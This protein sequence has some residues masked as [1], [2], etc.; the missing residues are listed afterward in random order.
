MNHKLTYTSFLL[1]LLMTGNSIAQMGRLG[2]PPLTG[3]PE[4]LVSNSTR[5]LESGPK[6]RIVSEDGRLKA[7]VEFETTRPMPAA[8]IHYGPYFHD[9]KTPVPAYRHSAKE[10]L[11]ASSTRH[12]V[13][14][15]LTSLLE[16]I[17]DPGGAMKKLNGGTVC[18]RLVIPESDGANQYIF[19][20][21]FEFRQDRIV[22]CI[23]EG[24]WIDVFSAQ[25]VVISWET[26]R[27]SEGKVVLDGKTYTSA[28]NKHHEVKISGLTGERHS[29][30]VSATADSV[31]VSSRIYEF[32][33]PGKSGKFRFAAMSDSRAGYGGFTSNFNGTNLAILRSL[34]LDAKSNGAEFIIF[35]GDMI[36]G[37]TTDE[38][39]YL[40]QMDA[41]KCSIEPVGHSVP[42]YEGI[43]NHD[44]V[45]DYWKDPRS[46]YGV[47]MDKVFGNSTE[48]LF[49]E[50][51]VNPDNDFPKPEQPEAPSYRETAYYFDWDNTRFISVNSN[52]W[53][54][55]YA[56]DIGGNIEGFVF[57]NQ[58]EWFRNL[59]DK[60]TADPA[61]RHIFVFTHE[62]PFPCSGHL[63]DAMWYNGG[64][65]N[66]NKNIDGMPLDRTHILKSRD[67]LWTAISQ[68][69]KVRAVIVGDEH[70]YARVRIDS[71]T[72]VYPNGRPNPRFKN[73]I[74]ELISGGAGAPYYGQSDKKI[75]WEKSIVKFSSQEHF[76]I[77]EVNQGDVDLYVHSANGDIIEAVRIVEN[78]KSTEKPIPARSIGDK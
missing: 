55:G 14:F 49:A 18:Y 1:I 2:M 9:Q 65:L 27:P 4:D 23:T 12:S 54:A 53:W 46:N 31:T 36:N 3:K 71:K 38:R 16:P 75:P 76:L 74:W 68:N 62:P 60:T 29:Y 48:T 33:T 37:H 50:C 40:A 45:I 64:D 70:N 21:R 30:S 28:L 32:R 42:I 57:N 34:F 24:P 52:Y 10:N 17:N 26:V 47:R 73:P 15:D 5:I 43:G 56:E 35:A 67:R 44:F 25:E 6:T 78:G 63:H 51:F 66:F 39:D 13:T 59:L 61:I 72:P 19:D 20:K 11:T 7:V 8:Y 58:Y 41:F 69:E 22:V 77:I